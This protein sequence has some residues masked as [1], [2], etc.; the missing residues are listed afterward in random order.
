MTIATAAQALD[1][2]ENILCSFAESMVVH[3]YPKSDTAMMAIS[4][5]TQA[6]ALIQISRKLTAIERQMAILVEK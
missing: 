2:Q 1:A 6:L 5:A 3:G 4:N